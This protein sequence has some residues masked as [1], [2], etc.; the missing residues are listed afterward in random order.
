MREEG[1]E[2]ER[3]GVWRREGPF[4]EIEPVWIEIEALSSE[5]GREEEST[6]RDRSLQLRCRRYD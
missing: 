1:T 5:R 6:P 3:E 2:R 4:R